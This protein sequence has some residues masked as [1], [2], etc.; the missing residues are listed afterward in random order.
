MIEIRELRRA[1]GG[2]V[3]LTHPVD[4]ATAVLDTSRGRAWGKFLLNQSRHCE[5]AC[6]WL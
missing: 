3:A 6:G 2:I 1:F 5:S 4:A